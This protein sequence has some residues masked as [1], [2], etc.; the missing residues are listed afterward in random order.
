MD[1]FYTEYINR[2]AWVLR[3]GFFQHW[4]PFPWKIIATPQ[5]QRAKICLNEWLATGQ[6]DQ[7]ALELALELAECCDF[8]SSAV[9]KMGWS[10][11]A[12]S[13][14]CCAEAEMKRVADI[15]VFLHQRRFDSQKNEAGINELVRISEWCGKPNAA[16]PFTD[17]GSFYIINRGYTIINLTGDGLCYWVYPH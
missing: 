6:G 8:W 17:R 10:E 12:C 14:I 16:I 2:A 9:L 3:T 7:N 11:G 1:I 5:R 15:G 4:G 13:C